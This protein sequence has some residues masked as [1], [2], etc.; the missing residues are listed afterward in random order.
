MPDTV[1]IRDMRVTDVGWNVPDATAVLGLPGALRAPDSTDT[2]W[3]DPERHDFREALG[4]LVNEASDPRADDPNDPDPVVVPPIYGRWHAARKSVD[5]S[6]GGWL[7]ELNLDPRTRAAAGM[8]TRVV[9]SQISQLMASAWTAGAG[10]D[11]GERA[12]A[13]RRR[14]PARR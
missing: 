12:A 5:P 7:D 3:V 6:Q 10:R 1:G 4:D 2:P 11:R 8:G 14:W 9:L 13:S